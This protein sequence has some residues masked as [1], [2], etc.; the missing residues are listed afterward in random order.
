MLVGLFIQIVRLVI[1]AG[2]LASKF[3]QMGRLVI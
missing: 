1:W 2:M 3:I